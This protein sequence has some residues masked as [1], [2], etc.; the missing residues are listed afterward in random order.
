MRTEARSIIFRTLAIAILV[1]ASAFLL[2]GLFGVIL[3]ALGVF[4]VLDKTELTFDHLRH[5]LAIPGV[6]QAI[7]LS[8]GSGFLA[9]AISCAATLFFLAN[10]SSSK[11][12]AQVLNIGAPFLAVPHAAAAFGL[13]FMISPSGWISRIFAN[14]LGL[15][16]PPDVIILN[17]PYG[18]S[19]VL[20]LVIKEVPFLLLMAVAALP[21]M[22]P[23]QSYKLYSSLGYD[24]ATGWLKTIGPQLYR[25]IRLPIFAVLCFS[26]SVVDVAIILGPNTPP[27]LSVLIT[28]FMS[29]PD[30]SERLTGSTLALIQLAVVVFALAIWILLEKRAARLLGKWIDGGARQGG[31]VFAWIATLFILL[32]TAL[33]TLGIISLIVWSLAGFWSYPDLLPDRLALNSWLRFGPSMLDAL[34]PTLEIATISSLI[35]YL[36]SLLL[37]SAAERLLPVIY[38]ALL[39]PQIVFLPGIANLML[40]LGMDASIAA[41]T[42]AHLLF[43]LPYMVLALHG[44]F[45]GLDPRYESVAAGLGVHPFLVFFKVRLPMLLGPSL[46]ALAIGFAVSVAQYLP[47]LLIGGGR[48]ATV[49]TEAVA[50]ASGGDRRVLGL[51]GVAQTLAAVLPFGFAFLLP[52]LIWRNRRGMRNG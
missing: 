14:F 19:L 32:S 4:P 47:T 52:S 33:L 2:S 30:I 35:A 36:L 13:A 16:R 38:L 28:R 1:I 34:C 6:F 50:L 10:L 21:Q 46:A 39:L 12:L 24:H 48:V 9:T 42:A 15:D 7:G 44:P 8:L 17:D 25:R 22:N 37:L 26:V 3:P 41:V 43:V 40:D 5:A 49:A 11:R 45:R 31:Q 18:L 27:T 23:Q 29:S 20:G 51:Y